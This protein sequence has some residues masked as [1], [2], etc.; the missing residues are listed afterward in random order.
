MRRVLA[1]SDAERTSVLILAAILAIALAAQVAK[2][3]SRFLLARFGR[4]WRD[5]Y[6][7]LRIRTNRFKLTAKARIREDLLKDREVQDAMLAHSRETGDSLARA[8][9]EL[10]GIAAPELRAALAGR[11]PAGRY[12]SM[13]FAP[14]AALQA[15]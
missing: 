14:A 10:P 8:E 12:E 1:A 13:L 11:E 15:A 2:A 9:S 3:L 6:R 7:A 5:V 4:T